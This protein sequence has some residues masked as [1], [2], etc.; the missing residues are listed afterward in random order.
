MYGKL[1][2]YFYVKKKRSE[3]TFDSEIKLCAEHNV[4]T[5]QVGSKIGLEKTA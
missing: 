4:R 3:L 1:S 5:K 2:A